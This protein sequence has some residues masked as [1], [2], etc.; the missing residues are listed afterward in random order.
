MNPRAIIAEDEPLL[1]E[2]VSRRPLR[3]HGCEPFR[4]HHR[5]RQLVRGAG[6]NSLTMFLKS[7]DF[8]E[9]VVL[10]LNSATTRELRGLQLLA[11]RFGHFAEHPLARCTYC[12]RLQVGSFRLWN[13]RG[14]LR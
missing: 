1:R 13:Q 4:R 12:L 3:L 6:D 5:E 9:I 11:N 8:K 14:H 10:L 2:V 7:E